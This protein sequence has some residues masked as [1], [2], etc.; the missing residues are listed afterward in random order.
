MWRVVHAGVLLT[1][2]SK[3][4]LQQNRGKGKDANTELVLKA[5]PGAPIGRLKKITWSKQNT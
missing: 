1:H 5:L 3:G 2:L 4:F